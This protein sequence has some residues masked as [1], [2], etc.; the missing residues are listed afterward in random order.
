MKVQGFLAPFV[1]ALL[2]IACIISIVSWLMAG[3]KLPPEWATLDWQVFVTFLTLSVAAASLILSTYSLRQ[4]ELAQNAA[5]QRFATE[6]E[7]REKIAQAQVLPYLDL[8]PYGDFKTVAGLRLS[9]YGLGPAFMTPWQKRFRKDG[10]LAMTLREV[11]SGRPAEVRWDK[12]WKE[13][14][15]MHMRPGDSLCLMEMSLAGLASQRIPEQE[16]HAI[17]ADLAAQLK[18]VGLHL[19]YRNALN[20]QTIQ[21]INPSIPQ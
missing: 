11:L 16:A 3:A 20:S 14:V 18:D 1:A 13:D 21:D 10:R 7:L 17:M 5:S 4:Q 8:V 12:E 9:N 19:E 6:N 15:P 2:V